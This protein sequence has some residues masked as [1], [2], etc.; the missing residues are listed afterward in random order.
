VKY[1]PESLNNGRVRFI[2]EF[3]EREQGAHN[4]QEYRG[5]CNKFPNL[6]AKR[7]TEFGKITNS[8]PSTRLIIKSNFTLRK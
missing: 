2:S 8:T 6:F 4:S 7:K 1:R 5:T 3:F